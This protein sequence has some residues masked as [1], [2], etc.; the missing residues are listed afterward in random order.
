[1]THSWGLFLCLSLVFV[2]VQGFFALF[3]MA[4]ISFNKMRLRYFASLGRK[5]AHWLLKLL[6]KPSRLFTTTLIGITASVQIGSECSRRFYEAV[7]LNPDFAPV[8]QFLFVVILG[9]L[10]PM[11]A[12]RR[13]PEQIAF[14]CAL[15]MFVF[16]RLISPL[17]WLF[18][19]LAQM[20]HRWTGQSGNAFF[21]L[22]REEVQKAFEE[23]DGEYDAFNEMVANV[24]RMKNWQARHLMA[25]LDSVELISSNATLS[26]AHDLLSNR[27]SQ[28]V[29]VYH[30][31]RQNIAA[32][33]YPQDL[34][35]ADS[36]KKLMDVVKPPWFVAQDATVLQIL[37][38]F[39]R[40]NQTVAIILDAGGCACGVLSMDQIV[41]SM[42]GPRKT[43]LLASKGLYV[44]KTISGS[45]TVEQFNR[46]FEVSLPFDP[47]DTMAD[48][49]VS[50]LGHP[51]AKGESI[52][53][54]PFEMTVLEPTIRGVRSISVKSID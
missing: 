17:I 36:K 47:G 41:D 25:S 22:S 13:H 44:E 5:R 32:I 31:L 49:I 48:W 42:F 9:E 28:F 10:I 20:I 7:G 35:Q 14:S 16:S 3:E 43:S 23:G 33:L 8:T 37:E 52:E 1:M 46:D 12:A 54:Y 21:V 27:F 53:V 19:M 38:Q 4:C 18:S 24:F 6:E 30:H 26:Q 15:I 2:I 51:P 39:R 45:M 34:L 11:F 50:K 40:N 29:L